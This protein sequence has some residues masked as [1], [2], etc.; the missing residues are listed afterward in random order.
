MP[1]LTELA[2]CLGCALW[3]A[4]PD[5]TEHWAVGQSHHRTSDGKAAATDVL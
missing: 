4:A 2:N 3:G 5:Q 1:F